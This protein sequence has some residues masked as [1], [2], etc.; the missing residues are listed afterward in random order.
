MDPE[1]G[2]GDHGPEDPPIIE[3][4]ENT[5]P[6]GPP[7]ESSGPPRRKHAADGSPV[8][9]AIEWILVIVGAVL[10]AL[11]VRNFVMQSFQIPSASMND[12]LQEGD[13]VLVNRLSYRLHDINRGDVIVFD[14][15]DSAPA[16][17]GDPDDLIKR[18]VGLPGEEIQTIDGVVRVDGQPLHEPY[19][20]PG[21]RTTG[22]EDPLRVPDDEV[23]VM[24]DNRGNS[25]DSRSIG[26]IP[27]DS[28]A[29]RAFAIIWPLSRFGGL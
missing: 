7:A 27:A 14:R 9:N 8:R 10:I 1:P 19:L 15:P 29:G 22:L 26:T 4:S 17:P 2:Q 23:F 6:T 3:D 24:G 21:V 5:S 13:R 16:A 25:S 11:I 18:V 12:T 20:A 28:V